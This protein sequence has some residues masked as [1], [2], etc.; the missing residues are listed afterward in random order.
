MTSTTS[1]RENVA[2][3]D[4]QRAQFE[5]QISQLLRDA[6]RDNPTDSDTVAPAPWR[7][8]SGWTL[9]GIL[10]VAG[11]GVVLLVCLQ[12]SSGDT[13]KTATVAPKPAPPAQTAT[14]DVAS[15]AATT[16]QLMKQMQSMSLD[17]ATLARKV[18][19]LEATQDRLRGNAD[20]A[21]QLKA[22]Q[23]QMTGVIAKLSE[24]LNASQEQISRNNASV[25]EQLKAGQEQLVSAL[26]QAEQARQKIPASAPPPQTAAAAVPT[27]KPT[28][29]PAPPPASPPT[30][31]Q[32]RTQKPQPAS[33]PPAARPLG[34]LFQ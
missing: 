15:T 31:V 32:A 6:V 14:E 17:L 18:D 33:T 25:A 26:A 4:I 13:T 12:W 29:K 5:E 3:V 1:D 22:S 7:L 10:S 30:A 23:E 2:P 19:Q 20:V 34:F 16:L 11:I 27:P 8:P 21:N 9:R 24:Q 28:P